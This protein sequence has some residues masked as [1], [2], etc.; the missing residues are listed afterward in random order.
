VRQK[1]FFWEHLN[2]LATLLPCRYNLAVTVFP[3][4]HWYV[5]PLCC[6]ELSPCYQFRIWET[7]H[8]LPNVLLTWHSTAQWCMR[9]IEDHEDSLLGRLAPNFLKQAGGCCVKCSTITSTWP[10]CSSAHAQINTRRACRGEATWMLQ[11]QTHHWFLRLLNYRERASLNAKP[12][13][14]SEQPGVPFP[15]YRW[16]MRTECF[17]SLVW[18]KMGWHPSSHHLQGHCRRRSQ[19][20]V[21]TDLLHCSLQC[22]FT[23]GD[24][25][26]LCSWVLQAKP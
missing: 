20:H 11:H 8:W 6:L 15:N 25:R 4:W 22:T 18:S 1:L 3:C 9:S 24:V 12:L 21:H 17:S 2:W 19:Q 14:L 7:R 16:H 26:P 10:S 5:L 13:K 23:D